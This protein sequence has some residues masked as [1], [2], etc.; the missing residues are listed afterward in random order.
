[1][2]M[3]ARAVASKVS[4]GVPA[5]GK[6]AV[7]RQLSWRR[8]ARRGSARC[9]RVVAASALPQQLL[10][11]AARA[12]TL[13]CGAA[14]SSCQALAAAVDPAVL[15]AT[16]HASAKLLIICGAVGWL[17]RSGRIPNSTATVLSKVGW[18]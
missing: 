18:R 12:G 4:A 1:M 15:A 16:L 17:L 6:P 7:A 11:A 14:T 3:Q 8:A 13:A 5:L 2:M 10:G 9:T